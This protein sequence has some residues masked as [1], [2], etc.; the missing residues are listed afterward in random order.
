MDWDKIRI[1]HVVA[2]SGSFT[3]AGDKLHSSQPAISRQISALEEELDVV[4]F[5]RHARGL[6]LTEQGELLFKTTKDIYRKLS[7]I[8]SQLLDTQK[9]AEGPLIISVSDF[10]GSTW[11]T[12]KLKFFRRQ[13]PDIQLTVLFEDKIMN[14]LTMREADAAIRLRRPKQSDLVQ[15]Q[16]AKID[17]H[18]CAAKR[19]LSRYGCPQTIEELKDHT[20]FAFPENAITP[21]DQVDWHIKEAGLSKKKDS[22]L[23]LMNSIYAMHRAVESG[24][25][26]ASLPDFLIEENDDI[27][28]ILPN[29]Q[30]NGLEMYFVYAEEHR[31]SERLIKF[32]DFLL[33]SIDHTVFSTNF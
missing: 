13:Y 15:R 3:K 24:A 10:I 19:Y 33:E 30:F 2:E 9:R 18:I 16:L 4:L 23:I 17:F 29:Y 22:N 20:V 31:H 21:F 14:Q 6:V 5:H 28:S 11:L 27:D 32:R 8:K 7:S 26:I 1:F 12:P 25:G